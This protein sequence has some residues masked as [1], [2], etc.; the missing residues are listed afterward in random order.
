MSPYHVAILVA[1][2]Q[3][4]LFPPI[5]PA[6]QTPVTFLFSF[7][8]FRNAPPALPLLIV[9]HLQQNSPPRLPLSEAKKYATAGVLLS[10]RSP[11][12]RRPNSH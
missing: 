2:T 1:P 7:L 5:H 11:H 12:H 8:F 3:P 6:T 10:A 9:P 4:L